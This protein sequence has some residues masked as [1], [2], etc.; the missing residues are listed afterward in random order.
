MK[1]KELS[2]SETGRTFALVLE[3]GE[4]AFAAI[5]AFARM[6]NVSA[7]SLTAIGAFERAVV[8]WFDFSSHSYRKIPVSEQCEVLSAL[9]DIAMGDD[10]TPSLHVHT[11]LGLQDGTTRGGHLLE[12][13]V[14]P[15]LEVIV[16][17]TPAHLHR[18]KRP[19]LGIALIDI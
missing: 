10:G 3:S 15:T 19:D 16:N 7:A 9:G 12:G 5:Q 4:E 18:R 11:V 17:E 13:W 2:R 8:G 14:N 6:E 1:H